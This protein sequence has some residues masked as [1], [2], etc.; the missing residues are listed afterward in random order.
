MRKIIE[1]QRDGSF[2]F[3]ATLTLVGLAAGFTTPFIFDL[4]SW[5]IALC[6]VDVGFWSTQTAF[7]GHDVGHNQALR[8]WPKANY[9]ARIVIGCVLLGFSIDWWVEKHNQHHKYPNIIKEDPDVDIQLLGFTTDQARA[10]PTKFKRLIK[11]QHV[12]LWFYMPFQAVNAQKS[13]WDFLN[14]EQPKNLNLQR[15]LIAVH[16]ILGIA[17]LVFLGFPDGLIFGAIYLGVFGF[18]NSMVFAPNHKGMMTYTLENMPEFLV[19]QVQTSR[20]VRGNLVVDFLMGGLNYQ[21]EHHVSPTTS[22]W[23]LKKLHPLLKD[24]CAEHKI[25]KVEVGWFRSV[26]DI[27]RH[28]REVALELREDPMG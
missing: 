25:T 22:R 14:R 16:M 4:P 28:M 13:S 17:F 10:R 2:L 11:F 9:A 23:N 15:S 1:E 12:L 7:L 19:L 26:W 3:Y 18:Y 8:R 21:G 27:F 24:F 6:A 20:N 5:G